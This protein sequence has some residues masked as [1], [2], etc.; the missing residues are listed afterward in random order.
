MPIFNAPATPYETKTHWPGGIIV[1]LF[2]VLLLPSPIVG[3][4]VGPSSEPEGG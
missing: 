3:F 2:N 4:L 1:L